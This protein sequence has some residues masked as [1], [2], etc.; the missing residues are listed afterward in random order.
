MGPAYSSDKSL[1]QR[2]YSP[3]IWLMNR[4]RFPQKFGLISLLFMLP[5]ALV[6]VLL[7]L[8]INSNIDIANKELQ[9]TNYLRYTRNLYQY[10]LTNQ[11]L[12][13]YVASGRVSGAEVERIRTRIDASLATLE[14]V[15]AQMADKLETRKSI[16]ALRTDWQQLNSQ[17]PDPANS[18]GEDLNAKLVADIRTLMTD[19]GNSSNLILDPRLDSHYLVQ[20]LVIQLP[21]GQ[22]IKADT[23]T[24]DIPTMAR[25]GSTAGLARTSTL[26]GLLQSNA[27]ATQNGLQAAFQ[28]TESATI[29]PA[30]DASSK[31]TFAATTDFLN[32]AGRIWNAQG[33][34]TQPDAY[35]ST[36]GAALQSG[37][38]LWDLGIAQLEQ[39]L[40]ARIDNLN[41]QRLI[42]VG[43]T[44]IVLVLVA[45]LWIGFYLAVTRT[46]KSLDAASKRMVGGNLNGGIDLDNHDE[47]GQIVVAF[48]NIASALVASSAY[49]QAIVDNAADGISTTDT[50]GRLESF[51]PAAERI[52]GYAAQE[53]I[54]QEIGLLVPAAPDE[55]FEQVKSQ[56]RQLDNNRREIE[57]RRKD[58][59]LFPLDLAITTTRIGD[60]SVHIALMRDITE[61]KQSEMELQKAKESA[62][63]ANHAKSAFLANMSHELRTPLNAII[64]Y[65]EMLQEEAEDNGQQSLIPDLQKINSAGKQLLGLIN[66]VLDLSKI[67]AGKMDLYLE[68]FS[69]SK[70]VQDVAGVIT[71]LI[72]KNANTLEIKCPDDIGDMR[73]DLTKLRQSIFNLL[74]NASKFTEH[75]VIVLEAARE[76]VDGS[77]WIALRVS[78]TGIG[79]TP[80]QVNKLFQEFTQA[81]ASTS[82]KYGG[83]GL[84]LALSRRFCR[85]MGGDIT[86]QSEPGKGSVFTIRLPSQ[87]LDKQAE[88]P[89]IAKEEPVRAGASKVLVIDDEPTARD[90]MKRLLQGQGFNAITASSGSEGL[91]VAKEAHPDII[92]LDVM[93]PGM[94]GWA[95]LATLKEDTATSD[96]PV[97]MVTIVDEKNLGYALGAADYLTKPVE[98][99]RL[100][101]V[102]ERYR[103]ERTTHP[104]LIVEDD[105]TTRTLLRRMLEA[106]GW[107]V[108]EAENGRIG[109]ER[110][111]QDVPALILLDLMMPEMD[112]FEF[113]AELRK[114]PA[115]RSVPVVVVTAK[116][117]TQQDR[118][119]LS[120]YVD[121]L[122][123]KGAYS[124]DE[125][126]ND[127]RRL[128]NDSMTTKHAVAT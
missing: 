34:D 119:R 48:N 72:E 102:L 76:R 51:N 124:R 21:E 77:D 55:M 27:S 6:M 84:G 117:L 28:N 23:L 125:L 47:L 106:E 109:L 11:V 99:E 88:I 91:Q 17:S 45:Y 94:D 74:S 7:I 35:W 43:I 12:V 46:V 111:A 10:A 78:D 24:L 100:V 87:V 5:L 107:S 95:V 118:Q 73:A 8:Q 18:I 20:A 26:I 3:A 110:V 52:F 71:P 14:R 54:G 83:T 38:K 114:N 65:S 105:A 128:I 86:V 60:E 40:Q 85:M 62:D 67:E 127:I 42:A 79:M 80:E 108:N 115:W 19:V 90:L 39:L 15:D 57:G 63:A 70:L 33:I 44:I 82:R 61:Q 32:A 50:Q 126:V 53:V 25:Q 69:V 97:I 112:G 2:L 98:R 64:G 68:T 104:V 49:R 96:I 116:D 16:Q 13:Q 123:Q 4:L 66:A 31:S 101:Q 56:E 22:N 37:F 9:G 92:T 122:L 58:G 113:V 36:G 29:Q 59:T 81:D 75:G 93:M 1:L 103:K 120:G 41:Q 121:Q 30:L 89:I